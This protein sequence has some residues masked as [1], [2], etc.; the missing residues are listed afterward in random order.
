MLFF[1]IALVPEGNII[2]KIREVR[3]SAFR[4]GDD[5]E[6]SALP[7]AL[8]LGFYVPGALG[9]E[10]DL[11]RRFGKEAQA[12]FES[13]PPLLRFSS[14]SRKD[15]RWYIVP[16]E[17]LPAEL[18]ASATRIALESGFVPLETP[19]LSP[20]SG[21]FAGNDVTPRPFGAFSFRHLDALLYR[22]ETPDMGLK[23]AWWT[24]LARIPRRT[25]PRRAVAGKGRK[26][27]A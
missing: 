26:P 3:E 2:P 8:F 24:V 20:G 12:L 14:A 23:S 6:A 11:A 7:E 22:V 5:P 15:G 19:P 17:V 9:R 16:D 25:G 18:A 21:F 4:S 27:G 10:K 13:L 1:A